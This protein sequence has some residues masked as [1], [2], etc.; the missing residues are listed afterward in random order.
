MSVAFRKP[1][2]VLAVSFLQLF[3]GHLAYSQMPTQPS[4][5]VFPAPPEWGI[6]QSPQFKVTLLQNGK[7]LELPSIPDAE[8]VAGTNTAFRGDDGVDQLR[9]RHTGHGAGHPPNTTVDSS[10]RAF[11]RA[12]RTSCRRSAAA[13]KRWIYRRQLHHDRCRPS[14]GLR[15]V[16]LHARVSSCDETTEILSDITNPLLVFANPLSDNIPRVLPLPHAVRLNRQFG[17][18]ARRRRDGLFRSRRVRPGPQPLCP[19]KRQA[20]FPGGRGLRLRHVR[21]RPRHDDHGSRDPVGQ[22]GVGRRGLHADALPDD[23]RRVESRE[24]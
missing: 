21:D 18:T 22:D 19:R 17:S 23:D 24:R 7:E 20:G 10:R 6:P 1:I 5:E 3:S 13:T 16:L 2:V 8:T 15:R 11:C 4:F 9:D 14:A 12:T